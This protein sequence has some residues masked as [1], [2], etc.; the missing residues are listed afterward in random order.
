VLIGAAN[1]AG[2]PDNITALIIDIAAPQE[3]CD[4]T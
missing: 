1:D 4:V 3:V 2:G